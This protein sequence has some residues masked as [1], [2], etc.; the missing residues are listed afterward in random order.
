MSN[1]SEAISESLQPPPQ[2]QSEPTRID[3]EPN[4]TMQ[5]STSSEAI[6][7]SLQPPHQE[8]SE[9]A[10]IDTEPNDTNSSEAISE[11]LQPPHQEQS[12]SIRIDTEPND[13]IQ[14]STSSEATSESL[15]PPHQEQSEPTRIDTES[16]DNNSSEVVSESLQPPHQEQ[17]EPARIDTEP[18]DANSSEVISESL[19]PPHQEQSEPTRIDTEPND[20]T[21]VSTSNEESLQSPHQEQSDPNRIDTEPND[22]M[23]VST[24]SEAISEFLQPPHLSVQ[25]DSEATHEIPQPEKDLSNKTEEEPS[26]TEGSKIED[27]S[28]V[29]EPHKIEESSMVVEQHKIEDASMTEP[30]KIEDSSMVEAHEIKDLSMIE[31]HEI[32]DLSM[33]ETHEIK[34]SSMAETLEIKDSSM[35]ET[36]EIKDSSMAETLEIKDSSMAET[37]EIKDSSMAEVHKADED[38]TMIETHK[39]VED[40]I[41]AEVH[42]AEDQ[43]LDNSM[44]LTD[45]SNVP[46]PSSLTS[47]SGP[48]EF[49]TQQGIK[50]SHDDSYNSHGPRE[51]RDDYRDDY[52][53]DSYNR[54]DRGSR[55]EDYGRDSK[56]TAY[57]GGSSRPEHDNS[58][59]RHRYG[60]GSEDRRSYHGSHYGPLGDSSRTSTQEEF[61]VPNAVVGLV[62]GRGGENL[63][64]IEKQTGARIQFSQDQPPD[65]IERRVTI[66]GTPDDVKNAK[67]MIQQLVDDAINGNALNRRDLQGG[68]NRS[69]ITI[70][71]PSGKVGVVIGRGGETIRD[72]Q[73]RS[74]ARINVTPDSA[75]SPQSNDRSVT[76][77]GDE[78]AVQRAK[79]LIDEIVNTGDSEP[80]RGYPK[81][82]RSNSYGGSTYNNNDNHG[83]NYGGGG[84]YGP[85]GGHPTGKSN[86]DSITIQVPND[87]VGL[88]IG[89][90]GETVRALQQ[91]S[92]AK[93]Q[94]EPV[95]GVPPVE[96]NV[97][98]IGSA[99]NITVAKQLIL[100]KAASGNVLSFAF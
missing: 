9:S 98:I 6:S 65:V 84:H 45:Y 19:Q 41:M 66:T 71:I 30:P 14:E 22:A 92:G 15:Q 91:Q 72:L 100:E 37:H 68:G 21:Q 4:D 18:D 36:L 17:S 96:R 74:G 58:N 39:T 27:S 23:Q 93:I 57:D 7:E 2:E 8:Q 28:M 62:I 69:T 10:R 49:N 50:R 24:S 85:Y 75:A 79:A 77:I 63:K 48:V 54:R 59:N 64:R 87:S 61:K 73:D 38:S 31:T 46:P 20:T 94:I 40:S 34:D 90:G 53:R 95:H 47:A 88:I 44:A 16:N 82:Y 25:A 81:D 78:A 13:T 80:N 35:A 5:V 51:S 52:R 43:L 26:V 60:I 32:K 83:N 56:R 3:T 67:G 11:S 86:Q 70:H 42:K 99:E 76:L 55:Y 97:Q 89:K 1:S 29:V 33:I 12:E